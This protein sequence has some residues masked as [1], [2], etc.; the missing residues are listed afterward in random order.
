MRTILITV[1]LCMTMLSTYAQS[2]YYTM[3]ECN[4]DTLKYIEKNYEQNKARYIG[5]TLQVLL[6]ESELKFEEFIP[7]KFSPWVRDK[8]L[9]GKLELISFPIYYSIYM[10]DIYIYIDAPYTLTWEAAMDLEGDES[11]PWGPKYYNFYK[12]IKIKDIYTYKEK[13][14]HRI[15]NYTRP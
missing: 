4:N 14:G 7:A 6:D 13:D 15:E 3:D 5:K 2:R 1:T 12:G 11:E 10:Y 8:S 9:I